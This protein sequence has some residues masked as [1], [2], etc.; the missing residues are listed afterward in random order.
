M[1]VAEEM[2]QTVGCK[3]IFAGIEE[4]IDAARDFERGRLKPVAC[5]I[6]AVAQPEK[7]QAR[8]G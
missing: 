3:A 6:G 7:S 5:I 4:M 8:V 2:P 1:I